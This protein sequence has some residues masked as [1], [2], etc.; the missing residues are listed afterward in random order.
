MNMTNS[1][2]TKRLANIALASFLVLL[3]QPL[4]AKDET[5]AT[6]DVSTQIGYSRNPYGGNTNDAGS[7]FVQ[8]AIAPKL[9]IASPTRQWTFDGDVQLEQYFRNYSL[10]DNYRGGIS[11]QARNSAYL[12]TKAR[13][14]Y[15]DQLI[16]AFTSSVLGD[17][18]PVVPVTG[19][20]LGVFGQRS[21]RRSVS[22]SAGADIALSPQSQLS[23]SGFGAYAAYSRLSTLSDYRSYGGSIGYSRA[24]STYTKLGVNVG[25]SLTDYTGSRPSSS[26]YFTEA[27]FST[28]ITPQLTL[29]GAI[30]AT[31][32]DD[33]IRGTR[34][35]PSGNI[36]LCRI[37]EQT[38]LCIQARRSALPS[39][40]VGTQIQ[41]SAGVS[42][43]YRL[44]RKDSIGA[45]LSY[46][47]T[48]GQAA[49]LAAGNQYFSSSLSYGRRLDDRF[50]LTGSGFYRVIFGGT[51][52][53]G[54]DYG[55]LAG[56]SYRFG[57]LR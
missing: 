9:V 45:N 51:T 24:I 56:I 16:G 42:Y 38:R 28:R 37:G 22:G 36:N 32:I 47:R 26:A 44:S 23:I 15:E 53:R 46:N 4:L 34:V 48:D 10:I 50:Q 40:I 17:S 33:G 49:V 27:S 25:A 11:Y 52:K 7:G 8:F 19:D 5:Q 29:D 35:S 1:L 21:R 14:Q 20:D 57:D 41:T 54:D 13:L 43:N 3:P 12:S 2:M 55:G 31:L 6:V 30:G 39:G 18:T